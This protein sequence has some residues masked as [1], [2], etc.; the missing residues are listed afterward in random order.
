MP[1]PLFRSGKYPLRRVAFF[2]FWKILSWRAVWW[3]QKEHPLRCAAGPVASSRSQQKYADTVRYATAG[4]ASRRGTPRAVK[5]ASSARRRRPL[6]GAGSNSG[7]PVEASRHRQR[8]QKKR[9]SRAR[10]HRGKAANPSWKP[11]SHP[12]PLRLI[13][14]SQQRWKPLFGI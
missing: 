10:A 7:Q 6:G 3:T 11:V 14:D 8:H 1:L 5:P 9:G 13:N 12:R 4:P 2:C